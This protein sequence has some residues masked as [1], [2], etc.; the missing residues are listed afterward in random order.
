MYGRRITRLL[1][2]GSLLIL[3]I[4]A[5]FFFG[6]VANE[7]QIP[8]YRQVI[9]LY[10]ALRSAFHPA[11]PQDGRFRVARDSE[12]AADGLTDLQRSEIERLRGIGYVSGSTLAGEESDV[13]VY[14]RGRAYDGFNLQTDGHRPQA[15]LLGMDGR[16]LHRWHFP[17]A[18]AFPGSDAPASAEGTK[19]WRR[20]K[21]LNDGDLLA[22]YEGNGLVKIDRESQLIWAYSGWAHHDLEVMDDG[23]IYVLTRKAEIVPRIN[24]RRPLLHDFIVVL[25]ADGNEL[26]RVSILEAIEGSDYACLLARAPEHGDLLH[27]NTLE[28]LDGSLADRLPAFK[29]GNVLISMLFL[30]TIAVV[31]MVDEK[32]VWALAGLWKAQHQPTVLDSGN[33]LVFD[34]L[35][36]NG[37][38]RVLEIDPLTQEIRWSYDGSRHEFF[39]KTCGSNQR[40]PNGNTLI[41]ESDN[42]RAFEVTPEQDIVWEYFTPNRAGERDK[43]IATLFEVDRL[44]PGTSLDWVDLDPSV[45]TD[46]DRP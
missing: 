44:E 46:M 23:R 20:V 19:Y 10:G 9:A 22:I 32:I 13:T 17:F 31:D 40:L 11:V 33:L 24:E 34:N 36:D 1:V 6:F 28:V 16:E 21:L 30:D 5:A 4:L 43:Y 27:T 18:A 3:V 7:K 12:R 8:P 29:A 41:T 14:D 42:G 38:S 45:R 2:C 15:L 35:G 37:W 25:D 26:R 39:S